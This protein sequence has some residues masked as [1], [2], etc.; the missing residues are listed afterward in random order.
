MCGRRR[1][2]GRLAVRDEAPVLHRPGG[3]V[4]DGD[5]V[6]L[7]HGEVHA[8]Q[9]FVRRQNFTHDG[10]RLG[11]LRLPARNA[12]DPHC[13]AAHRLRDAHEVAHHEGHEVGRHLRRPLE[14][15]QGDLRLPPWRARVGHC[16]GPTTGVVFRGVR[17]GRQTRRHPQL[18]VERRLHCGLVKA[19]KGAAGVH[20][21]ELGRPQKLLR[22]V[23]GGGVG[24]PVEASQL[25]RQRVVE[26]DGQRVRAARGQGLR[27]GHHN[28]PNSVFRGFLHGARQQTRLLPFLLTR[29][30]G[31]ELHAHRVEH[32]AIGGAGGPVQVHVDLHMPAD[33]PGRCQLGQV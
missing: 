10:E 27:K 31:I 13:M 26:V 8:E 14:G 33:K 11:K 6:E 9:G 15:V 30:H 5:K 28:L 1:Q 20:T 25:V 7:V 18:Q 32:Y 29:T 17:Q 24:G 21:L 19:R 12:P 3:E 2:E 23:R 4:R 16:H 22:A